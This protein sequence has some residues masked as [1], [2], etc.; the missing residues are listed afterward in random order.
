MKINL[1]IAAAAVGLVAASVPAR[2]QVVIDMSLIT[3]G[4]FLKAP[5]DR[6]DVIASWMAGYFSAS[7]NLSTIDLRYVARN[8]KVV[9]GYCKTHKSETLMS[10]IQKKGR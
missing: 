2:A 5:P 7:K 8:N 1:L 10:A 9:G 6:Q 3:C 4:D